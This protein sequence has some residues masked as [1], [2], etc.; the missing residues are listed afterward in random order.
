MR[1]KTEDQN[2]PVGKLKR[3]KE[4]SRYLELVERETQSR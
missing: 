2:M 1:K 3:V 4:F